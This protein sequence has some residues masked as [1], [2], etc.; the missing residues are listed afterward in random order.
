MLGLDVFILELIEST[1]GP[2]D[3]TD[4]LFFLNRHRQGVVPQRILRNN[5]PNGQEEYYGD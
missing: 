4:F 2:T 1:N 3:N 5:R